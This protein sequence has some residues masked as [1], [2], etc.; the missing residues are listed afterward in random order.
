MWLL[1]VRQTYHLSCHFG[2][3]L[4]SPRF[5]NF[6]C[7]RLVSQE[8]A[9]EQGAVFAWMELVLEG[10]CC[11]R[12]FHVNCFQLAQL[13]KDG[14]LPLLGH[15]YW[16][17]QCCL[18]FKNPGLSNKL[19]CQCI[20]ALQ[21]YFLD[22][23]LWSSLFWFCGHWQACTYRFG[24]LSFFIVVFMPDSLPSSTRVFFECPPHFFSFLQQI[25]RFL[26]A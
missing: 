19:S 5:R 9:P 6:E 15:H 26:E 1:K 17:D 24:F 3:D 2:G 4:K 22:Q 20:N 14:A 13:K 25:F 23:W 16:L 12:C 18:L 7:Q 10:K 11:H 21:Y 8:K